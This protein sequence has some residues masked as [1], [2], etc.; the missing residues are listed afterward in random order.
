MTRPGIAAARPGDLPALSGGVAVPDQRIALVDLL[1]RVLA[2][3]IVV[4]G[5]LTLS[6]AEVDLVHISVRAL[7]SSVRPDLFHRNPDP[8]APERPVRG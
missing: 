8:G 2:R 1:D 7:L 4:S 3:G 6:I 5:E